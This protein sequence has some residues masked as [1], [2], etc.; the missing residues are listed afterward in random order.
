MYDFIDNEKE[1]CFINRACKTAILK[2]ILSGL[3]AEKKMSCVSFGSRNAL[4]HPNYCTI[5]LFLTKTFLISLIFDE[6]RTIF[7]F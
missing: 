5:V 7:F 4:Y 3:V 6:R 2:Q 1:V